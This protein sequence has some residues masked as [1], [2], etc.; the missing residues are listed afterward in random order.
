MDCVICDKSCNNKSMKPLTCIIK[1]GA[2]AHRV[3]AACWFG[4]FAV[5]NAN[6]SCP[7]CVRQRPLPQLAEP[8]IVEIIDLL[9]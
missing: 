7:G 2:R 1:H 9:N 5:E 4:V 6:H 3:C 8:T